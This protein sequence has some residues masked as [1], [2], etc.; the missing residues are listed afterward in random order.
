MGEITHGASR[1]SQLE[2]KCTPT[3][4]RWDKSISISNPIKPTATPVA[5]V[6][7]SME[8]CRWEEN[9]KKVYIRLHLFVM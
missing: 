1:F 2:K 9:V 3:S 7:L 4:I 6:I 8:V 5:N